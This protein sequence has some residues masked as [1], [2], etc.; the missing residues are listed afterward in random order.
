MPAALDFSGAFA[1]KG[2]GIIAEVKLRSPSD[3]ALGLGLDPVAAALDYAR[4]GANALS[5]L[6]EPEFF[7][8][9]MDIFS[10]VRMVTGL[11]LLMKDFFVDAYQFTQARARGADA[12]LL[13]AALLGKELGAMMKEASALGLSVLVEVHTEDEMEAA[14]CAGARLIGIN[15]RNL[16]TLEVDLATTRRLAPMVRGKDI[17]LISESG[18]RDRAD[19]KNLG[20]LG[21]RGFLIGTAFIKGGRPGAALAEIL[22][23]RHDPG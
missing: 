21:C 15:N 1:G 23:R 20:D 19:I 4:N 2:P 10:A 7:G 8:G 18:I 22:G 11:P 6:T 13:I 14:L 3:P 9:S 16:K 17:T 12:V 5:I